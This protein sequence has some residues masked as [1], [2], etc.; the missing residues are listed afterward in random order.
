MGPAEGEGLAGKGWH[1]GEVKGEGC[2]D[3]RP[4]CLGSSGDLLGRTRVGRPTPLV[5]K[6]SW[7]QAHLQVPG[8]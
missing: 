4:T 6:G 1:M 2:W 5:S 7:L 3:P 8:A